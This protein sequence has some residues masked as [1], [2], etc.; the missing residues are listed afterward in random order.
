MEIPLLASGDY[1]VNV[2]RSD[3]DSSTSYEIEFVV[4]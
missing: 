1:V 2:W 4:D 3:P